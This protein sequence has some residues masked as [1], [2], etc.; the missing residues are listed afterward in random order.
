MS[1]PATRVGVTVTFLAISRPPDLPASFPS[2]VRFVRVQPCSVGFYRYLYS[3]IGGDYLWWMRR[4]EPD[5]RLA[6][7][8]A[9]PQVAVHV[10]TIGEEPVG[11][12]E[13]DYRPMG[14]VNIAYFGLMRH[15][16]GHGLG[17]RFLGATLTQAW[18]H[19]PRAVT[20]N[21]CTADHP[22]ALPLYLRAGFT[23]L[24]SVDEIWD[25]PDRVGLRV[26]ERLRVR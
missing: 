14:T 11:I 24:R 8:L 21:T 15:V 16:I 3:E 26:P 20:V 7:H 1:E 9:H 12:A 6:A 17:T 2:D 23:K 19:R 10:L 25:I 18:T 22:R 4:A 13:L 5:V